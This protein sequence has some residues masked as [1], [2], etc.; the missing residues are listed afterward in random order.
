MATEIARRLL[1]SIFVVWGVITIIF[2]VVRIIPG[3]PALMVLGSDATEEQV[4]SVRE[5]MG[6][7][8]PIVVQYAR[9]TRGVLQLDFGDSYRFGGSA[10]GHVARRISNS[11]QLAFLS[12]ALALAVSFPL[13]IAAARRP[14]GLRDKTVSVISL[15]GLS[16]PNFRVGILLIMVFSRWLRIFPSAGMGSWRHLVLPAITLAL[17]TMSVLTRLIR[18]GLLDVLG[19]GYIT[20]ARAKGMPESA[21]IYVHALRNML[22]PVVTVA[23]LQ[24]GSLLGGQVIV[25]T[26]F[27]WPG[28][29]RLLVTSIFERD[30]PV[31][32]AAIAVVA[33]GFVIAN[34][35][36][37]LLYGYLD[38]RV[39][40]GGRAL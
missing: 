33:G 2:I 40:T 10:M 36:V 38:P 30:F 18:G 24:F 37:D 32:Q 34:L 12:M 31:V 11:A 28:V 6:V 16:L 35:L 9:Y 26:V 1:Y 3:D 27:S 29:G 20:T 39:R 13:G 14:G 25:E 4:Q 19:E 8:E 17:P 22:L 15:F 23:G 21:V 5:A 7:T